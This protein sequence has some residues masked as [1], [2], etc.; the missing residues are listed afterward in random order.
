MILSILVA[1]LV[2]GFLV[3]IHEFGHFIMAK[4]NG[5]TVHEFAIGMGPKIFSKEYKGTAYSL[6][7]IP[8][9]GFVQLEGEDEESDEEGSLNKKSVWARFKIM[10]AGAFM[11]LVCGFLIYLLIIATSGF[12]LTAP[13]GDSGKILVNKVGEVIAGTPAEVA[14]FQADDEIIKVDGTR[15]HLSSEVRYILSRKGG[16][17]VTVTVKRNGQNIDLKIKPMEQERV[18]PAKESGTGQDETIKDYTFGYYLKSEDK[19]F[20][21]VISNT[22]YQSIYSCKMI[23]DSL[24][25]LIRGEVSLK[26][27]SGPVGIT[28]MISSTVQDMQNSFREGLLNLLNLVAIISINLGI[29][30]LL[31]LPA[32]DGGR[33]L[34]LLIE[35]IRRKPVK[36][37]LEGM[38][39]LVG[40]GIFMLLM[41][42]IVFNDIIKII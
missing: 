1:I 33:I 12:G 25:D 22:F 36:R 34:F 30:N 13:D 40:L 3:L 14:G 15:V 39:H 4:R 21:N 5:V 18:I 23:L 32:L 26:Q 41:V 16:N 42:F 35:G 17:E 31:P 24:G 20:G 9:G 37:E 19:T 11:N 38:I 28:G 7:W 10:F 6:R 29:F 8:F 2:F 27:M